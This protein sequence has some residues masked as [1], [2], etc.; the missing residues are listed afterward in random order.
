MNGVA[1]GLSALLWLLRAGG[2]A[3]LAVEDPASDRQLPMLEAAGLRVVRVPWTRRAWTSTR[4]PVRARAP[5]RQPA[6]QFPTGVVLS[7][8]AA[9]T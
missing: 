4:S 7:P 5:S 2:H 8:P 1:H 6:H 9:P 3:V